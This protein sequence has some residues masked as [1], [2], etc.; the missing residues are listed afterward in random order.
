MTATLTSLCLAA[1][2]PLTGAWAPKAREALMTRFYLPRT[3]LLYDYRTGE[4]EEGL[5]KCMPEAQEIAASKP[6]ATGWCTGMED[7]VLNGGPFLLASLLRWEKTG[8]REAQEDVRTIFAGL[9]K[10]CGAGGVR[11]FLA[12]SIS[13]KDGKSFYPNSSRDQYTLFVYSLWRYSRSALATPEEKALSAK[14]LADIAGFMERTVT[15]ESGWRF[16]NADG[17]YGFVSQMWTSSP[18]KKTSSTPGK[19][20]FGGLGTHEALRLPMIY[21]AAYDLTRDPHW[22]EQTLKYADDGIVMANGRWTEKNLGYELFQSQVSIRLLYETESDPARKGKYL[23][24]L[25]RGASFASAGARQAERL[26]DK[27]KGRL[28]V[29]GTDWRTLPTQPIYGFEPKTVPIRRPD[30]DEAGYCLREAAEG[31]LNAALCPGCPVP[32]DCIR[33]LERVYGTLDYAH[34]T[35]SGGLAHALLAHWLL[36]PAREVR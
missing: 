19:D 35:I 26:Y 32:D 11:G 25:R 13:P 9:T 5:L 21:A 7:S 6:C 10:L 29:Y 28:A 15:A 24:L 4:G 31:V 23:A 2:L 18:G 8:E 30:F 14:L 34:A 20:Y 17:S 3:G 1:T 27:L 22:R 33:V 12:R 16:A 36:A